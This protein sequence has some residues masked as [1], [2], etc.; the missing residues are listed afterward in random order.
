MGMAKKV[1]G[2]EK[3]EY[4]C[5]DY[6]AGCA[7]VITTDTADATALRAAQHVNATHSGKSATVESISDDINPIFI[8]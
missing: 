4:R 6:N 8:R 5:G 7:V 3:Y 2:K 1:S